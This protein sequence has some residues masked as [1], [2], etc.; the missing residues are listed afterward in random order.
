M[1]GFLMIG[2]YGLLWFYLLRE[3][4]LHAL[5]RLDNG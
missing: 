4:C 3:V 1:P 5:G 2:N